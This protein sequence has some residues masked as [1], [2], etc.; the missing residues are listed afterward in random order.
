MLLT[1]SRSALL[2]SYLAVGFLAFS[3]IFYKQGVKKTPVLKK[4]L[5]SCMFTLLVLFGYLIVQN[6]TKDVLVTVPNKIYSAVYKKEE[7]NGE[8]TGK[9]KEPISL[10]RKDVVDNSDISNMRFSIW[11]SSV[12]IFKTSPIYGTSPRNLLSYAHDKLP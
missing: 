8:I 2:L 12:E 9:R 10:D 11:K 6:G 7:V 1:G 4:I 5:Y 3:I